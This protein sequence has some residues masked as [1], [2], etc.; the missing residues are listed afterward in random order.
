MYYQQPYTVPL[1]PPPPRTT[2]R[3]NI[4]QNSSF[5]LLFCFGGICGLL[6]VAAVIT[7]LV[8]YFLRYRNTVSSALSYPDFLCSQRPCGCPTYNYGK[9]VMTKIVGGKEALPFSYPWLVALT[10]SYGTDPFCAGFIISSNAILTAAHCLNGR[11]FNQIQILGKVHDVRQFDGNRYDIEKWFI[12]PEYRYNDSMHLNDIALIK[13]RQSFA[14][15][16]QPACLPTIQ[17]SMYPREKT[18][19]V[20]SGWGTL[21]AKPDSQYSPILQHVVIPIVNERNIK[22]RK[23]IAD[24]QRQLCAGYDNLPIDTCSGDSGSPLLVVEYTGQNQGHFVAAGIVSYGNRKCDASISSGV[25]TRVG[26]YL[27]WIH[28]ALASL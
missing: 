17:S 23:S 14:N 27:Q 26:F 18:T 24:E 22:C 5:R 10:D 7:S 19:A 25:Y 16:L 13:I 20:V 3:M 2:R 1:P 8:I 11:N 15:D 6:V 28:T 4:R 9:S 12:H 21:K